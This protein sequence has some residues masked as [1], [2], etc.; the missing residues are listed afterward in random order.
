[1]LLLIHFVYATIT[2]LLEFAAIELVI[3]LKRTRW[4]F[5]GIEDLKG[6]GFV[7][8]ILKACI[9]SYRKKK[10]TRRAGEAYLKYVA[11]NE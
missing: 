3:S 9:V 6:L 11:D 5:S 1:M 4:G 2:L 8:W 10:R 7:L